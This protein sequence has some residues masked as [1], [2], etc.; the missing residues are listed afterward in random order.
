MGDVAR[1]EAWKAPEGWRLW[2]G[3]GFGVEAQTA[4]SA[5][6]PR[7]FVVVGCLLRDA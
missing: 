2:G 6:L 5:Q 4:G 1:I 7:V 3:L